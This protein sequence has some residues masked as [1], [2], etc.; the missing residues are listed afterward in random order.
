[1]E[2]LS[3][4]LI[5]YYITI[6]TNICYAFLFVYHFL[7]KDTNDSLMILAGCLCVAM[8]FNHV[9]ATYMNSLDRTSI[10]YYTFAVNQFSVWTIVNCVAITSIYGLHRVLNVPFHYVARYVYR[11]ACISILFN[12]ALHVDIIMLGNR[13]P[14]WLW[15]TYSY[16]ENVITIFMF[17]SVLV[18]RKWS[19]V[20]KWLQLAH[21]R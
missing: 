9:F 8:V 3:T 18:A 7:K 12:V 1:M 16:G 10:E 11:G 17:C 5:V 6:T 4:D 20:F 14:Y 13:D 15:T 19:E 21:A 2:F